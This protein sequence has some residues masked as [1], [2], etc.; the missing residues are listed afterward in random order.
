MAI[1]WMI[2]WADSWEAED[3]RIV[4]SDQQ[5]SSKVRSGG[6][7]LSAGFKLFNFF[8]VSFKRIISFPVI[9]IIIVL[10]RMAELRN[11]LTETDMK[12]NI[13]KILL[14]SAFFASILL[15]GSSC[16]TDDTLSELEVR[17]MIEQALQE[18]NANLEFTQWEIVNI[19]ANQGDW[20][21]DDQERRYEAIYSLPE[22]TEFIYENGAVLGYLFLGQQG[23][24]EVQ[25]MLPFVHTYYGTDTEGNI[26]ETF[27]E[28]ISYDV[29]YQSGG[30]SDVAFFIQASDVY[31]DAN[32]P[33]AYNFRLVLIW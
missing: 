24:N 4:V 20:E 23:V 21:W 27:T 14:A 6:L 5:Q 30:N 3:S 32:A 8:F 19:Q 16:A 10:M 22:L 25:K 28:T 12:R 13:T 9:E 2:C 18:N 1:R 17:R 31:E 29:M 11:Q 33:Q 26:T 7:F 15:G